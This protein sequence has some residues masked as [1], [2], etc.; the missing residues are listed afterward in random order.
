[1][2]ALATADPLLAGLDA[3]SDDPSG[4]SDAQVE[5]GFADLQR[6]S[7]AVEAK[8]L[9]WL[10]EVERRGFF[11]RDGY[12]SAPAWLTDRFGLGVGAAK[13]QVRVATALQEMPE[14]REAF[15]DGQLTSSAVRLLADAHA[16]HPEAF[17]GQERA[18]VDAAQTRGTDEL[19]RVVADWCRAVD[20]EQSLEAMARLRAKRRIDVWPTVTGMVR[21]E[22]EL[23]PE[24][25]EAV[26]TALQAMV[27]ADLRASGGNDLRTP[28]QRRA[29]ALS[30]L[31]HRYLDRSDRPTVAGERPHL[32]V[33]V[34]VET[35]TGLAGKSEMDHV[36]TLHHVAA[37]RLA[38]DAHVIRVVLAGPSEPLEVGRRTAV[39]SPALRRAL[40]IRD[41]GCRFPGCARPHSWCDA[42]HVKHWGDGGRTDLAN[43]AL[44]CRPHHRLVHEGGFGMDVRAGGLVFRRPDGSVL[45][46]DRAPP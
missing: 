34:D 32:T 36:G 10:G 43:L 11:R 4:L 15:L 1:M 41:G 38:C 26:L 40:V 13:A 22:G 5:S 25:G 18:L 9:R 44:L 39:V 19:R 7:E 30:E 3:Y 16:D 46:E 2:F 20:A 28:A 29:D 6:I 45:L 23:D 35:L 37:R 27:D 8:R 12:L 42:H 17:A 21:V 24:G 31:A 14:V 33:T